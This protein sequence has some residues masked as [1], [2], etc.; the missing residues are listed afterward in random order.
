MKKLPILAGILY[1]RR[2]DLERIGTTYDFI[3]TIIVR[4]FGFVGACVLIVL[5]F[6]LVYKLFVA[7]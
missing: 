1:N 3:V 2:V 4:D 7:L 5:Y 6:L